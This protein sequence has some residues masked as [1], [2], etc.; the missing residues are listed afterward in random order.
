MQLGALMVEDDYSE[1]FGCLD[2]TSFN[3]FVVGKSG[4]TYPVGWIFRANGLQKK[5]GESGLIGQTHR[6]HAVARGL[7][8]VFYPSF[9]STG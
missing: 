9:T 5:P 7:D 8:T 6:M 3:E 4:G 1:S 2:H